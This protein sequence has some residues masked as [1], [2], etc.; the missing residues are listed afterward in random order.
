MP[1]LPE[2]GSPARPIR[3]RDNDAAECAAAERFPSRARP[4]RVLP[5][6][7]RV[8]DAPICGRARRNFETTMTKSNYLHELRRNFL[9]GIGVPAP[10]PFVI[11]EFQN[12]AISYVVEGHDT[13]VVAPTGSG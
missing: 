3:C 2:W 12:E 5:T 1:F 8:C 7:A 9:E 13:L 10:T 4:G 11:D 6:T